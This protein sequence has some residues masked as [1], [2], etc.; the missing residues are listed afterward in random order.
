MDKLV[1]VTRF[2]YD[3]NEKGVKCSL[4][5]ESPGLKTLEDFFL[6]FFFFFFA[7]SEQL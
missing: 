6:V 5:A 7:P 3:E 2:G 1:L 4:A